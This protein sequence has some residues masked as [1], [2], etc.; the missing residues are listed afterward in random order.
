MSNYDSTKC[1]LGDGRK[2]A[3]TWVITN[4]E[5]IPAVVGLCAHHMQAVEEAWFAGQRPPSERP[6]QTPKGGRRRLP[7]VRRKD[8]DV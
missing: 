2:R 3:G 8:V 4:P 5:R 6:A 1:D 7:Y